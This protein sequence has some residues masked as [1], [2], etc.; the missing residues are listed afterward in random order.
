MFSIL[1]PNYFAEIFC[2]IRFVLE[3]NEKTVE[4]LAVFENWLS[5][6]FACVRWNGARFGSFG[7][8]QESVLSLFLF[9][10][11]LDDLAKINSYVKRLFVVT[12][13]DDILLIAPSVTD[14]EHLLRMC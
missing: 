4:L 7:V 12:C 8:R 3:V 1:Q 2:S 14:L 10:I 9:N 13:A 11:Y 6:C 5:G